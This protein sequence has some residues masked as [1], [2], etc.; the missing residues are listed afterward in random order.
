MDEEE[1]LRDEEFPDSD[2]GDDTAPC[3]RCRR[4]IHADAVRCP[5][6]REY[7]TPGAAERRPK[8]WWI[9][10]GIVLALLVMLMWA[11]R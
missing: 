10:A 6:C 1:D 2:D 4:P 7:V 5:N 11:F 8:P 9:W 3:P